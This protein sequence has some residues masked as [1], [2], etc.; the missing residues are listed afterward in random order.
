MTVMVLRN[1]DQDIV[2]INLYLLDKLYFKDNIGQLTFFTALSPFVTQ[3]LIPSE[4]VLKITLGDDLSALKLVK[5]HK[6][7]T[8]TQDSTEQSDKL[9][10]PFFSNDLRFVKEMPTSSGQCLKM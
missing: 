6:Q 8:H 3:V 9:L 5:A 1:K 7:I 4:V 2:D 10:L